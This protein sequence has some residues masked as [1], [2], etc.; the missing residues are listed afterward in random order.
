MSRRP[1]VFALLS[2]RPSL[3]RLLLVGG[4]SLSLLWGAVPQPLYADTNLPTGV[5]DLPDPMDRSLKS[6]ERL[7][8]LIQRV[9]QEQNRMKTLQ[10]SF[11]QIRESALLEDT[12]TSRG[13]FY[14]SAPDHVRWEYETPNPISVVL[15]GREMVTWYRDL[16]RADRLKIGRYSAQV[17]KYLGASG[18]METLM[19]YFRVSVKFPDEPGEDYRL[20]LL[21]K[22]E[23]ISQRLKSMVL[24]IDAERYLPTRLIYESAD[25]DTTE[26]RFED[27]KI[28]G[29]IP[30]E[31]FSL[32]LPKDVITRVV[33]LGADAG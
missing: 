20:R 5:S 12:E 23:R 19:D 31:R 8:A 10:A 17:F 3:I 11:V 15:D 1:R 18:S 32:D 14:Y 24:W 28:N 25:G 9:K 16:K 29:E 7:A 33:Q 4:V 26:Y 6:H 30:M 13:S 21:P 2:S 22:Y 27:F